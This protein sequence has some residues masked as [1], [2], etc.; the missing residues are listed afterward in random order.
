MF[1]I[2][3]NCKICVC[4]KCGRESTM[5]STIWLPLSWIIF[6]RDGV[7]KMYCGSCNQAGF[8]KVPIFPTNTR[9]QDGE[10]RHT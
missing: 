8:K 2:V 3:D 6:E 7:Y 5:S 1:E 4:D 10:S 9:R